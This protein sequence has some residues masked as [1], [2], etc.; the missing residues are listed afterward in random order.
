[1]KY[2]FYTTSKKAW[3]GMLKTIN[4]AKKSIYLEMYIFLD[5]NEKKYDFVEALKKKAKQGVD[6]SIIADVYGSSKM[7]S[8]T[9]KEL[10]ESGIEFIFFSNWLRRTHRK[11]LI[12][13][14]KVA[15]TGGVNINRKIINWR[16]MQIKLSGPIVKP[17]LKSFARGYKLAG[18]KK[19][20]IL[21]YSKLP[22]SKR[23]KALVIDN[24][25][26]K[27]K[28]VLF[29]EY[30]IDKILEAKELVYIVTPYL[31]PPR[32]LL[33]AIDTI[34]R[35][36]VEVK[37]IIPSYTDIKLL[38]KVNFLNACR[39][40][41][42][43]VKFFLTPTMNHAKILLIDDSL[44]LVG[45]QNIDVLSFNFNIETGVFFTQKKVVSDLKKI[46]Y[47]WEEEATSFDFKYKKHTFFDKILIFIIK[48][49]YP[50][51]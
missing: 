41:D 31:A 10:R 28:R 48:I 51:F 40:A 39:L 22:L 18:G 20:S 5:D 13:D 9:I 34:R 8:S 45:S 37:I 16:D 6:I 17:F 36:G 50:I 35:K 2:R 12:V 14:E 44:G 25:P 42:I 30:Y 19:E 46:V 38:N 23:I 24:I 21:R 7:P 47:K 1:M 3:V 26:G 15:F 33:V 4:V 43:G 32:R 49:F 11:I 27:D 29:S